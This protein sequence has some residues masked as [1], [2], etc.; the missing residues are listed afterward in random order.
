ML[1]YPQYFMGWQNGALK[2]QDIF[3][4]SD[5]FFF[6]EKHDKKLFTNAFSPTLSLELVIP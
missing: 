4:K 3:K 1:R 2:M 6:E 5:F